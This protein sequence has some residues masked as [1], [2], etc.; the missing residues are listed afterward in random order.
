[1]SRRYRNARSQ[2]PG[3]ER[4]FK[5]DLQP[6]TANTPVSV[7]L[8]HEQGNH[9]PQRYQASRPASLAMRPHRRVSVLRKSP[10]SLG[11]ISMLLK[12][13]RLT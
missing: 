3:L 11:A 1:M 13:Y 7:L 5:A 9:S 12:R 4:A 6:D 8:S 10:S 2:S